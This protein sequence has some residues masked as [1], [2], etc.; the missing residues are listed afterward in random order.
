MHTTLMLVCAFSK[1]TYCIT[2]IVAYKY[3]ADINYT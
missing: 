2:S 1:P 3:T